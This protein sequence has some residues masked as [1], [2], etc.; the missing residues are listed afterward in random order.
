MNKLILNAQKSFINSIKY[1]FGV[2][3]NQHVSKDSEVFFNLSRTHYL[4]SIQS[5]TILS[6]PLSS[7]QEVQD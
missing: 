5:L 2:V 3:S 1:N 7:V 4:K 6:M